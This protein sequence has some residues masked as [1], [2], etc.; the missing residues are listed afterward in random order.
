[1]FG[2]VYFITRFLYTYTHSNSYA[3][4]SKHRPTKRDN[5]IAELLLWWSCRT[6]CTQQFMLFLLLDLAFVCCCFFRSYS[7]FFTF[8]YFS[9]FFLTDNLALPTRRRCCSKAKYLIK[10]LFHCLYSRRVVQLHIMSYKFSPNDIPS[11]T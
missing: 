7:F 3:G 1:M 8:I 5:R 10:C 6:F 11:R 2:I 4:G 9:F